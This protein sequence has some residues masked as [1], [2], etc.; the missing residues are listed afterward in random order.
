LHVERCAKEVSCRKAARENS[1]ISC[2]LKFPPQAAEVKIF[3]RSRSCK[4]RALTGCPAMS[5]GDT[6][7]RDGLVV[8]L[9]R[10]GGNVTAV[11]VFSAEL[12]P[13]RLQLL[14]E[15]VPKAGKT[16]ALTNPASRDEPEALTRAGRRPRI[17]L[18]SSW[19][20]LS[21]RVRTRCLRLPRVPRPDGEP[22][23]PTVWKVDLVT[24]RPTIFD[25]DV[26]ALD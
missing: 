11:S 7:V 19:S 9:N 26:L 5:T 20:R 12:A 18:E 25:R 13:K 4:T 22:H 14:C 2:P 15:L 17:E 10:P 16:A 3:F 6:P 24:L 8:S 21:Q 1:S 23:L